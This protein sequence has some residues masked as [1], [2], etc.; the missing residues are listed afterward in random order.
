MLISSEIVEGLELLIAKTRLAQAYPD[1]K[2]EHGFLEY[3]KFIV[4]SYKQLDELDPLRRDT[5]YIDAVE[6][7]NVL[8]EH[9]Q[10]DSVL[11]KDDVVNIIKVMLKRD[12]Q[13]KRAKRIAERKTDTGEQEERGIRVGRDELNDYMAAIGLLHTF[14]NNFEVRGRFDDIMT[15]ANAAYN[16][17][18]MYYMHQQ[19]VDY[20]SKA[21]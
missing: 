5:R 9:V 1:A 8:E 15:R 12:V 14:K 6:Y 18:Y 13:L 2:I 11:S 19:E 3:L 7:L 21:V 16:R 20:I 17:I 10:G 4:N